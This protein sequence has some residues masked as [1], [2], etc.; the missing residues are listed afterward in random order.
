M[1]IL[2]DLRRIFPSITFE[3]SLINKLKNKMMDLDG[4]DSKEREL[5]FESTLNRCGG[6]Q[7]DL[8]NPWIEKRWTT[9]EKLINTDEQCEFQIGEHFP[10]LT[11]IELEE[12]LNRLYTKFQWKDVH[13]I[14]GKTFNV[15][16]TSHSSDHTVCHY[17]S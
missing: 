7:N 4:G 2:D 10:P 16:I 11:D 1:L 17:L 13:N 15:S 9:T 12:E 14:L 6:Q 3:P 5:N 8:I